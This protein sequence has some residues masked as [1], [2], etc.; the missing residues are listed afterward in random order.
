LGSLRSQLHYLVGLPTTHIPFCL[1]AAPSV[2]AEQSQ[3]SIVEMEA[4]VERLREDIHRL[5]QERDVL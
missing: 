2:P 5:T 1:T 4:A 3:E